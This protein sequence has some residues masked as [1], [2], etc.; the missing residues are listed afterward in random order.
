MEVHRGKVTCSDL[1]NKLMGELELK[2]GPN[3]TSDSDVML[4]QKKMQP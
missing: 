4:L 2:S 3:A 1:H